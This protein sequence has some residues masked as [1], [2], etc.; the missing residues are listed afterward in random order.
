MVA[1]F[2]REPPFHLLRNL[3]DNSTLITFNHSYVNGIKQIKGRFFSDVREEF[4]LDHKDMSIKKLFSEYPIN[5]HITCHSLIF[6]VRKGI[7]S[8]KFDNGFAGVRED[9]YKPQNIISLI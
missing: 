3:E 8:I 9:P 6:D 5:N 1:G 7:V 4:Y 2:E